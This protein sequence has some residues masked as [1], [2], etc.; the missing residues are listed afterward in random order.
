[1]TKR[2]TYL[3]LLFSLCTCISCRKFLK[4][5]S[6]DEIKP[7]TTDDLTSLMNAEAYPY[8]DAVNTFVDLLTDDI[9][10]NGQGKLYNG[11]PDPS[12]L[13]ALQ[14]GTLVFNWDPKMFDGDPIL[15]L[16]TD[17]Y[18][19]YYSKIN[20]CNV[21]MDN[22]SKVSGTDQQKNA[23]LGQTLFLRGY[24][25]LRLVTLYSQPFNG[26]GIDP[27]VSLGVP[28]ILSSTVTDNYPTRNTI[29]EV[30]AQVEKDLKQAAEL[31]KANFTPSTAFRAGHVAAYSLL[32]RMYLYMGRDQDMDSV[33]T[34]ANKVL[35][36]RSI[37]TQLTSYLTTAGLMSDA[38][39]YNT[40]RSP[41]VI[42]VS[43]ANPTIANGYFPSQ[44][45]EKPPYTVSASLQSIYDPGTS[46]S[47]QGDLR[48]A[49]YFTRW[50]SNGYYL[51]YTGKINSTAKYGT[52]GIRLAEVYLNRAE[53]YA[54]KYI[55]TGNATFSGNALSDLNT[56]RAS[57]YDTRNTAYV[58]VNIT[59]A[60]SLFKFC[61][62]ERRR[63]LCLEEC[64][65]W[66]DIKRWGLSISHHFIAAD[67][68]TTDVTLPSGSLVYALPIPF[69]AINRNYKLMQNPR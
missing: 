67:G 16:G 56:L 35:A 24:Y 15:S 61:Q 49:S 65:R 30:Y 54:R 42:W 57:R 29:A 33:V 18:S 25:Y 40:D 58:P 11:D 19:I 37:L 59:D 48:Y 38:G 10:S 5:T 52:N 41:E 39:I 22:L 36:E 34:Y 13:S 53:A 12:Y 45:Y 4:E 14:N 51:N 1:M 32:S 55:A 63:E 3:I 31:L 47:N 28:L 66:V 64:H 26:K 27:N 7:E 68:S 20:G 44:G 69:T 2:I 50:Y 8:Q 9:Q 23:I 17:S 46:T 60:D 6:P 62:D 43:G 21:V